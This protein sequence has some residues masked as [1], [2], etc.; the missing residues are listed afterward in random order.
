MALTFPNEIWLEIFKKID[1][2]KLMELRLVCHQFYDLIEYLLNQSPEWKDL[3][4]DTILYECLE[5]TM[6]RAYPY[7]LATHWLYIH[8]PVLWRGTYLSYKKWQKVLVNSHTKDTIVPE[9]DLGTISCLSTFDKY[10]AISF[11]CGLIASYTVDDLSR[12]FYLANHGTSIKEVL[13]WYSDGNV[14]F[15]SLGD[16]CTMKFWDLQNKIE[17]VTD[18][19]VANNISSGEC[20]H[21]CIADK[22]GIVTS[23]ERV[24]N[25]VLPGPTLELTLKDEQ[26]IV[27]H[28]VDGKYMTAMAWD[29][30]GTVQFVYTAL[31]EGEKLIEFDTLQETRW[32]SLPTK[33]AYSLQRLSMPTATLFFGI[34]KDC[35]GSTNYYEKIWH[36]YNLSQHF[37]CNVRSIALHAQILMFGLEDGSIHLLYIPNH[38]HVRELEERIIHSKKIQVDT[39]PIVDLTVLEVD[40]KPCIVAVTIRKVHLLNFF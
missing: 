36:E 18:G 11:H 40:K 15:V 9:A 37:G 35:I 31:I 17:I 33:L 8:D 25:R 38:G 12:P 19:F 5:M 6:Q 20:R 7:Y 23:Y 27:A 16:D 26:Y 13:F 3:A 22:G 29:G 21:F 2:P 34:G 4:H 28:V 10:I 39:A 24:G 1:R 32:K 14:M 30:R